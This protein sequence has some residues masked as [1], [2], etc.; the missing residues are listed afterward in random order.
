MSS[1]PNNNGRA[2]AIAQQTLATQERYPEPM[3]VNPERAVAN[4]RRDPKEGHFPL[5]VYQTGYYLKPDDRDTFYAAQR[6]L[7]KKTS[8]GVPV[9][10]TDYGV[11]TSPPGLID[12]MLDKKNKELY[13]H[14]LKR[15]S[16][17]ADTSDPSSQKRLYEIFPE[18]KTIPD[19]YYKQEISLQ[20]TLRNLLRDGEIRSKEDHMTVG[21]LTRPEF[22]IPIYP[23]WDPTGFF[24]SGT[25]QFNKLIAS[26]TKRG[27]FNPLRYADQ[28]EAYQTIGVNGP[29]AGMQPLTQ[30]EL[31]RMIIRRLYPGLRKASDFEID[32]S[33]ART[34]ISGVGADGRIERVPTSDSYFWRWPGTGTS[35]ADGNNWRE[36]LTPAQNDEIGL[37]RNP[38]NPSVSERMYT[39][40]PIGGQEPADLN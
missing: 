9:G 35:I 34:S 19:D 36:P 38:R 1:T 25:T 15:A 39:R 10:M 20:W 17:L 3:N 23:A 32:N 5:D 4:I 29:G 30:K 12:Y 24:I 14:E 28:L 6:E 2:Q 13:L 37:L 26:G 40:G 16:Y 33:I 22:M 7:V 21:M 8:P 31:K 18:L 11:V 27:L